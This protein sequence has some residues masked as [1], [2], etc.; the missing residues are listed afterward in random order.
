MSSRKYKSSVSVGP[1]AQ[2]VGDDQPEHYGLRVRD[3]LSNYPPVDQ[4]DDVIMY[5][6]KAQGRSSLCAGA[7]YL[8]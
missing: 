4:W 6:A 1:A 2:P 3:T 5:D 7:N 8:L